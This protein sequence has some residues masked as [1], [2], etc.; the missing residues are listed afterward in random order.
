MKGLNFA[1]LRAKLF[2]SISDSS[3]WNCPIKSQLIYGGCSLYNEIVMPVATFGF[4]MGVNWILSKLKYFK[5]RDAMSWGNIYCFWWLCSSSFA[6]TSFSYLS[7]STGN[8]FIV[9][10]VCVSVFLLLSLALCFQ[11]IKNV[12][13]KSYA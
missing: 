12:Y 1:A 13:N 9:S 4:L 11:V 3:L 2:L 10:C 7:K 5:K 6:V 8:D